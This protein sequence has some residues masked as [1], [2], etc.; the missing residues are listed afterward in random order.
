MTFVGPRSLERLGPRIRLAFLL[1]VSVFVAHD[2]VYIA[3][4]GLGGH[5]AEVMTARGHD[6]YWPALVGLALIASALL[7]IGALRVI[8]RLRWRLRGTPTSLPAS[9][10]TPS[11]RPEVIRIWRILFPLT[12]LAFAIQENLEA[13]SSQ[14]IVPGIDA[15]IGPDAPLALPVLALVTLALA[16]LGGLVR[17]R[18]A[19]LEARVARIRAG[20]RPRILDRS[21]AREWRLVDSI[22][23]HRWTADRRDAGRAPPASLLA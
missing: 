21:P 10:G 19:I 4:Y 22:A 13:L 14:G 3:Q 17:W 20:R 5:L 23:P 2:G 6:T 11:W 7:A 1:V 8:A 12:V 16:A 9:P 15:L 18:I